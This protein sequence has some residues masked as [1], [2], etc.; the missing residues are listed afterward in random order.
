LF[1]DSND[2]IWMDVGCWM[3]VTASRA[4]VRDAGSLLSVNPSRMAHTSKQNPLKSDH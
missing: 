3:I 2:E 4:G 1:N